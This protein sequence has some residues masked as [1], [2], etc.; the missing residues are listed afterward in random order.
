[1]NTRV[2][3]E[4]QGDVTTLLLV[5]PRGKPVTLSEAVL[6]DLKKCLEKIASNPPRLLVVKSDAKRYFCVGADL[7]VLKHTNEQT[8]V[9]WVMQGHEAIN[10]L[11][12]LNCPTVAYVDGYA[13]GGGL[14]LA[15]GCDFIY[16]THNAKFGQ[17]EAKLGFIPGW[18]GTRRLVE[19]VGL[20]RAKRLLFTGQ[21]ID[22]AMAYELGLID[23]LGNDLEIESELEQLVQGIS[24]CSGHAISAFKQIVQEPCKASRK[25][26]AEIEALYS[27]ECIQ[28][29]DTL[30][31]LE[32]FFS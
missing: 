14:E 25:A 28:N 6:L 22:A 24:E 18:G 27:K 4:S 19:R 13:L 12:D 3:T 23:F 7:Q 26:N 1:M 32:R 17:T 8:I 21:L 5:P 2:L 11:E 16:A 31:R 10:C 20:A 15:M 30:T 29:K 9:P